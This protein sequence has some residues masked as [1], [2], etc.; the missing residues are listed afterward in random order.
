VR[1]SRRSP[2]TRG[3]SSTA[4]TSPSMAATYPADPRRSDRQVITR[5]GVRR[6]VLAS[7]LPATSSTPGLLRVLGELLT[8][9][10]KIGPTAF[11]AARTSSVASRG[12][13][14]A[15]SSWVGTVPASG[16][17]GEKLPIAGPPPT[18]ACGRNPRAQRLNPGLRRSMTGHRPVLGLGW[19]LGN[20]DH[21][22]DPVLAL[23]DL[24][25]R[26]TN[27]ATGT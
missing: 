1:S 19:P 27:R 14:H 25:R 17:W 6:E 23:P 20:V 12:L 26:P 15:D 13:R 21:V 8:S 24:P 4:P 9:S 3:L 18:S 2:V 16:R 22:R 10:G 5:P 11:T 7:C